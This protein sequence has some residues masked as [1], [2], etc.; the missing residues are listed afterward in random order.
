M[1]PARFFVRRATVDDLSGLKELWTRAHL[2]V[3]DLE[4]RLTD[5]QLVV[6]EES[7][8]MAAV[9]LRVEAGQGLLHSEAFAGPEDQDSLRQLLWARVITLARNHGLS[10]LWTSEL[11]PFWH[12]VAEFQGAEQDDL[13]KLPDAFGQTHQRWQTLVLRSDDKRAL[14]LDQ[15]FELFQQYS[16]SSMNRMMSQAQ[17]VRWVAYGL[18]GVFL[19]GVFGLAIYWVMRWMREGKDRRSPRR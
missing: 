19:A 5:F 4:K 8:L 6:S 1:D 11:A 14:S 2:Q 7:D 10:Q 17:T 16:T 13:K 12:Q 15:E 9:A 3:L 18:A